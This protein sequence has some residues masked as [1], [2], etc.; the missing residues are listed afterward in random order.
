MS[1][2]RN[3]TALCILSVLHTV[4]LCAGS[5]EDGKQLFV[6]NQP[7]EAIPLLEASLAEPDVNLDVYVY[8]PLA[9][10][11]IGEYEKALDI[12]NKGLNIKGTNRRIIAFNAGNTAFATGDYV[13]ANIYYSMAME[14]DSS[15]APPVLNRANTYIKLDKLEEAVRDY[16]KYLTLAPTTPQRPQILDIIRLLNGEIALR[17]QQTAVIAGTAGGNGSGG[18]NV[19]GNGS[20]SGSDINGGSANNGSVSGAS[21][22]N[23]AQQ[24]TADNEAA[25]QAEQERLAAE[26]KAAED[27][28][29]SAAAARRK[30]LLEDVAASLQQAET[31]KMQAGT[32]GVIEYEQKSE[33]D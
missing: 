28:V 15:Y 20:G 14:A 24:G 3:V 6:N 1:V 8:L 31:T 30:K 17:K 18:G 29:R 5:F 26:R 19:Q 11:Q 23:I 7:Q 25:Q 4:L 22:D 16:T 27:A 33:L 10:Y 21:S 2:R 32:E 9:Y 13:N 12:S